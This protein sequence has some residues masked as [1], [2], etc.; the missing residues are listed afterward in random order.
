MQ[1]DIA[2]RMIP[3][4]IWAAAR[5]AADAGKNFWGRLR[6]SGWVSARAYAHYVLINAW[7]RLRNRLARQPHVECPCCGWRGHEFRTIDCGTFTVPSAECPHCRAHE[8]HRMLHIYLLRA[9]PTFMRLSGVALHFAPEPQVGVLIARN[10]RLKCLHTDYALHMI[11]AHR[12]TA[13]QC[14]MQHLA[15]ADNAVHAIFCLHVLEHVPDD[16]RGIAELRRVLHPDGAAYIMVP[17]MMDWE[18]TVEF[19]RPDPEIYDHYRGYSPLDF[20]E[21]L[22]TF[23]YERITPKD[24][25]EP[26][27]I[28]RYRIPPS[29]V[30]FRCVK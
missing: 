15:L 18:K 17:F 19:G 12:G 8:R 10:P 26:E 5:G 27:E 24:F 11:R 20:E 23:S 28:R 25:L 16:R 22:A 29:Q 6:R 9:C 4:R 14:D 3:H 13:F 2:E 30:I 1:R 7:L 21:R